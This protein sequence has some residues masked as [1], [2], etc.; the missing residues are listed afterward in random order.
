MDSVTK[1]QVINFLKNNIEKDDV[2][3]YINLFLDCVRAIDE[4]DNLT[5]E[6]L[7]IIL[8]KLRNGCEMMTENFCRIL[9]NKGYEFNM[10]NIEEICVLC[11]FWDNCIQNPSN[12]V[13]GR[14]YFHITQLWRFIDM[15]KTTLNKSTFLQENRDEI[16]YNIQKIRDTKSDALFFKNIADKWSD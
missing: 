10:Q 3:S 5:K 7:Y 6:K 16:I 2:L 4:I 13:D 1:Q 12:Q 9:W 14:L 11:P 15:Y 8:T